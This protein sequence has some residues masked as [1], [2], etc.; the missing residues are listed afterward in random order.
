MP[1][2]FCTRNSLRFLSALI[3]ASLLLLQP[4]IRGARAE[5]PRRLPAQANDPYDA[6][7]TTGPV[8]PPSALRAE[9]ADLA[10]GPNARMVMGVP[11]YYWLDGCGPTSAGMIL[12]Y[13]DTHGYDW[14]IPGGAATETTAVDEA[15]ASHLGT[16]NHWTDYAL[17]MDDGGPA[18]LADRSESPAGDEHA[19]NSVA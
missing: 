10:A 13:W 9:S 16:Q 7:S 6:Q 19:P 14:L 11:A 3:L 4:G 5:A 12:G 18:P 2:L 17:P 15:I 1:R 8:P